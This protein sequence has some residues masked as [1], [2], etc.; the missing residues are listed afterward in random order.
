MNLVVITSV[1]R[2]INDI[3]IYDTQTRIEQ[4]IAS[5]HSVRKYIP[6]SYI[7]LCEGGEITQAEQLQFLGLVDELYMKNI[8][9]F[10]KS[11]G[12]AQLLYR[13]LTSIGLSRIMIEKRIGTISKLSG[14]YFLNANFNW[15]KM[16]KDKINILSGSHIENNVT[17][18][19]YDTRYYMIP[20]YYLETVIL[21]LK[22]YINS[23]ELYAQHNSIEH[24]FY[25]HVIR[26]HKIVHSPKKMGV[27]GLITYSGEIIDE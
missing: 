15:R 10:K 4:T 1:L 18:Y 12:E 26:N 11:F 25:T 5:I 19:Y 24:G 8:T 9:E 23:G 20:K 13:Y 17:K 3:T 21:G 16:P 7:V 27:S 6:N 22:S 14:R 2:P